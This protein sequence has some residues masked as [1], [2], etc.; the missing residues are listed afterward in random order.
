MLQKS[1]Y[2]FVS[3]MAGYGVRLMLP[4]FLVRL[5]SVSDFGAYRQFFL[6]E[7]YIG[8]L[9]QLGLNQALFYF[10]PRDVRNSGAYLLN[11]LAMNAIVFAA[12]F[13]VIG[14][15]IDPLSRWLN[16]AIMR[17]AF[18][19]L[20]GNVIVLM[21]TVACDCYLTARQNVKAAAAFEISGQLVMSGAC[22]VAAHVWGDLSTIL[23]ALLL[24]RVVQAIAMLAF[25]HLRLRGFSAE[26]Y[27]FGIRE[28]LRYGIVLGASGTLFTV[29]MRLHEF[30]VSRYYGTDGYAIYSAG[31]TD[32]PLV[33]MFTQA[34]AVVSLSQFAVLEKDKDWE[35]I[36]AVWNRVMASSY[37]IAVPVVIVLFAVADP[38]IRFMFTDTYADAIP[39]FRVATFMKLAMIF[40]ATLV[41]RAMSRNDISMW[42]NVGALV[43]A[44]PMY[45]AGMKL[46]GMVGIM[47]AQAL[48]LFGS[49]L[50]GVVWMNRIIPVRLCYVV[51][52]RE[53]W[54]FYT[55]GWARVRARYQARVQRTRVK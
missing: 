27:F 12:A 9:F 36:K 3:K 1:L 48:L 34:V 35:G 7:M 14:L 8:S 40:N 55:D 2:I 54:A 31:A 38:L 37:A 21:V 50:A 43:L 28:Q 46:G 20:A 24:A 18:W 19:L 6:L 41:L 42:T 5:L 16:M 29:L 25:I 39:I 51:G 11:T 33:R 13:V 44:V 23:M 10:I 22:L 15:A 17:D 53:Q 4:Y 47:A 49:R 45:F 26:R 52:F 32:I 30:F